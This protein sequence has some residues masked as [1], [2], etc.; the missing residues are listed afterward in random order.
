MCYSQFV[1]FLKVFPQPYRRGQFD[2]V[3]VRGSP[4]PDDGAV[5]GQVNAP[6]DVAVAVD[7]R[8]AVPVRI[9]AAFFSGRAGLIFTVQ[10]Q[11]DP[12]FSPVLKKIRDVNNRIT[13]AFSHS[14]HITSGWL[15]EN[16]REAELPKNV[17]QLV[18]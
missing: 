4:G 5:L 2:V 1:Q 18:L 3:G 14:T 9:R 12:F 13:A 17:L 15:S 10:N 16:T 8:Q 6:V 7:V 11:L